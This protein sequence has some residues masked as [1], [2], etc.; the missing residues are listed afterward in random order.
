[1]ADITQNINYNYKTNVQ[2]LTRYHDRFNASLNKV[3]R[4]TQ[5]LTR[6]IGTKD[7]FAMKS[8]KITYRNAKA[9]GQLKSKQSAL[10]GSM[11]GLALRF[12][13]YNMVLNQI[14]GAQQKLIEWVGKS[15]TEFREFEKKMAEVST[16]IGDLTK[17]EMPALTAGVESLSVHFGKSAND[18]AKGLYDILSAAFDSEDAIRLLT[19]ATKASIA[20]L[21]D[22]STSVDIFTSVLN[23]YG[24]TASQ[25]SHISDIFFQTIRRGKLVFEDLASAIGYVTPI[26][27]AAGVEFEEIA[28]ILATVTRMGLHVDMA[29]RGLALTIQN[30]VSPTKQAADAARKYSIDMS[31][32]ALRVK[33]L[34]GFMTELNQ[35]VKEHGATILPE[36]IRNMRSL[37]VV[38]AVTSNEGI[39]GMTTDLELM[40]KSAG[41][42][43]MAMSKMTAITQMQVD[44]LAQSMAYL[45]RRIGEAWSGFDIWWKKTQLWWGTLLSGGDADAALS[46]FDARVD[47]LNKSYLA[48][49]R[50][51]DALAGKGT[52]MSEMLSDMLTPSMTKLLERV[53]SMSPA[54]TNM[55]ES[56]FEKTKPIRYEKFVD[57]LIP[58]DEI[59]SYME[60]EGKI[61]LQS[62]DVMKLIVQKMELQDYA[63]EFEKSHKNIYKQIAGDSEIIKK[64]NQDLAELGIDKQIKVPKWGGDIYLS[65]VH[66][67]IEQFIPKINEK[68]TDGQQTLVDYQTEQVNLAANFDF[69]TA[70]LDDLSASMG[71]H[72]TNITELQS[73]MNELKLSVLDTYTAMSGETFAGRLAWEID[74]KKG[75][76]FLDRFNKFAGMAIK[77]GDEF[78]AIEWFDKDI[79]N[80]VSGIEE[81]DG[82]M[83]AV[84]DTL[85]EY[86]IETKELKKVQKEL[87][88]ANDELTM[89][90]RKNNLEMMKIQ[91]KGMMRRRGLSRSEQKTIKKIEIE[92]AGFRI[93]QL[94]KTINFEDMIEEQ[95]INE[96]ENQY[97]KAK[98]ILDEYTDRAT[99]NLYMLKDIRDDDVRDLQTLYTKKGEMLAKYTQWEKDEIQAL[100]NEHDAYIKILAE[101][102]E[103]PNI[104]EMYKELYGFY[105]AKESID[106]LKR[107]KDFQ[108][109]FGV[110]VPTGGLTGGAADTT[111]SNKPQGMLAWFL[112]NAPFA[113]GLPIPKYKDGTSFVPETQLAM[114]H[115]GERI[116]PEGGS[117]G[118]DVFQIEINVDAKVDT[119]YDVER[120]AEKLGVAMQTQLTDKRGRSKYRMR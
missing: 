109:E 14:M 11:G 114:V 5:R 42:T 63:S 102:A 7:A 78:S 95:H 30:I 17:A 77:Y 26:A 38:M 34:H 48:L 33:G 53:S 3:E 94:E 115:R 84:I 40:A 72:K 98:N 60:L 32:L 13:G 112:K 31:G 49:L 56:T 74:V 36:L 106:E 55:L 87:K 51:Q 92:N 66:A 16:I 85:H 65:N 25:A 96:L 35:A 118:G 86:S 50:T 41:Q 75:E 113:L 1:M 110:S 108:K 12:V 88:D 45:E 81:Y 6:T 29:S 73:A 101:I 79:W 43:E 64:V 8:E 116:I 28:A 61:R 39:A 111:E 22:V 76:V 68:I 54:I 58:W 2:T 70:G 27:A 82:S 91:L 24:M 15:I 69:L 99:F 19:T 120:L 97:S 105:A 100:G 107:L 10:A 83:Q 119:D 117:A 46:N 104:D 57:N 80:M 18:M 93:E 9:T 44:I 59:S 89:S 37:R 62:A 67:Q 90:I 103:R 21:A 20:G 52:L 23:A 71:K 47:E 4:T